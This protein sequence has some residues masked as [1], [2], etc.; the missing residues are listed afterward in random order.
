MQSARAHQPQ[1]RQAHASSDAANARADEARAGLLPQLG[2]TLGYQ[3]TTANF[4]A[5]PGSVPAGLGGTSTGG[6]SSSTF[7]YFTGALTVSQLIYD[8]GQTTG[9]YHAQQALAAASAEAERATALQTA[10]N[11]R[12]AYFDARASKALAGVAAEALA[13]LRKHLEQI[14]AFVEAGTRP[15]IDLFQSKTDLANAQVQLINAQ[16]AY[17]TSKAQL[18]QAMGIEGSTDYEVADEALPALP[19]EDAELDALV[20]EALHARPELASLGDQLRA[21]R[22]TIRAIE[23]AYGPALGAGAGITQGGTSLDHLGWNAQVG[24]TLNWQIYQGGLTT[25]QRRE[26]EANLAGLAA[27]LD[28]VRQQL[29]LEVS[30]ARLSV[31]AAKAALGAGRDALL[32]AR[33]RLRLAEGRYEEGVGSAIELGDAQVALTQAGAQLVQA[34]DRLATARAQLLRALGRQ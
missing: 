28:L 30:Q 3:R 14:Q 31:R 1:L 20:G 21:Q 27:Q 11:A 8:F 16:N 33:E 12:A 10:L 22:E 15:D 13:N 32:N 6:S 25:A 7:N 19:G 17:E 29:R 23:G 24:L 9:R 18:N 5:R 34:D 26:A 2:A 4:V